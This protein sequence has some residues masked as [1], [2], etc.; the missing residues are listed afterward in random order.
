VTL[1]QPRPRIL[2]NL[3]LEPA[4]KITGISRYAFFLLEQ[5][6]RRGRF[7]FVVA[8]TWTREKLPAFLQSDNVEVRTFPHVRLQPLNALKQTFTIRRLMA[9]TGAALEYNPCSVGALFGR[10]PLLLTV[11]DLYLKAM[12]SRYK[13]THRL[14]WKLLFPLSARRASSVLC[15]SKHTRDELVRFHPSTRGKIRVMHSASGF[16]ADGP[17]ST[18]RGRPFGL[19]VCNIAANKGSETLV[20][21]MDLLQKR[22][23][24]VDIRHVGRDEGSFIARSQEVLNTTAGPTRIGAISDAELKSLYGRAAFLVFPSDYEGFGLPIIEAQTFGLPVIAS[25]IPVLTEVA[26]EGAVFFERGDAAQLA[27]QIEVFMK[28]HPSWD[29]LSQAAIDNAARFSWERTAIGVEDMF[30]QAIECGTKRQALFA[31]SGRHDE[32]AARGL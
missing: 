12:P 16:T 27:D 13:F 28:G 2:V 20:A 7:E 18:D 17:P 22:G 23:V 32:R 15:V 1:R 24:D 5:L 19:F 21:A 14:W 10:W 29:D 26:G 3:L 31:H 4:D 11:H 8:T 25:K 30:T 6:V 9:E